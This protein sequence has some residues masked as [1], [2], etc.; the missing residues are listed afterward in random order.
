MRVLKNPCALSF[1]KDLINC[2][3]AS[4]C[5]VDQSDNTRLP[6]YANIS[7]R[8]VLYWSSN[9]APP[10]GSLRCHAIVC[11]CLQKQQLCWS[12]C[13]RDSHTLHPKRSA[14]QSWVVH[15]AGSSQHCSSKAILIATACLL[16]YTLNR[17]S[18]FHSWK[19]T[20][21]PFSLL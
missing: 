7:K 14:D 4:R 15:L 1:R 21:T 17:Y 8:R 12:S 11:P 16:L 5:Q 20:S 3:F 13:I 9:L 10:C 19:A 18:L 2:A 6:V